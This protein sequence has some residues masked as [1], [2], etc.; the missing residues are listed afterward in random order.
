MHICGRAHCLLQTLAFT[1]LLHKELSKDAYCS[2]AEHKMGPFAGGLPGRRDAAVS[3]CR[4]AAA[5]CGCCMNARMHSALRIRMRAQQGREEQLPA[6]YE[7][8]A[9]LATACDALNVALLVQSAW[10]LTTLM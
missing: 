8:T 2:E 3:G 5:H 7:P 4:G 1:H 10:H 6:G 9:G